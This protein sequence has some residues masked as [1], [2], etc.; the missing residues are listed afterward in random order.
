LS[1]VSARRALVVVAVVA[2][3]GTA[4]WVVRA[5]EPRPSAPAPAPTP[6]EEDEPAPVEEQAPAPPAP[7]RV[8]SPAELVERLLRELAEG[9]DRTPEARETAVAAL[10][11]TASVAPA[12]LGAAWAL[13]S[14]EQRVA[15]T[16]DLRD[17]L[18][19]QAVRFARVWA[20]QE[21]HVTSVEHSGATSRVRAAARD[22]I[23]VHFVLTRRP[24]GGAGGEEFALVD[25]E[26][27][28]VSFVD[29]Y[30]RQVERLLAKHDRDPAY[31]LARL[32]NKLARV[33]G[34]DTAR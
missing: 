5:P 34:G 21:P 27:E 10:I 32:E 12:A 13:F 9:T 7:S 4:A 29:S 28:G 2:A 25:V 30:R 20:P 3:T 18:T 23:E 33:R 26:V 14:A 24:A 1:D 11:D 8:E 19:A 22:D 15:A 31:I 17:I 6:I 16:R